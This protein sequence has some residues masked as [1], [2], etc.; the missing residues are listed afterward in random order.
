MVGGNLRWGA[1]DKVHIRH[2]KDALFG[3][4]RDLA[5]IP[6]LVH[7]SY[8]YYFLTLNT[9][10]DSFNSNAERV[11]NLLLILGTN[12]LSERKLHA[13]VSVEVIASDGLSD[14]PGLCWRRRTD[15]LLLLCGWH[16]LLVCGE[17]EQVK[18]LPSVEVAK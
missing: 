13:G 17:N 4:A 5:L 12:Y 8:H 2:G 15:R 11:I 1:F 16:L 10:Q 7:L 9:K 3:G 14:L 6:V 18:D